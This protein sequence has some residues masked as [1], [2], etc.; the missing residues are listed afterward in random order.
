MREFMHDNEWWGLRD[1]GTWVRWNNESLE[2][3]AQAE[4]PPSAE[5][6][7][8]TKKPSPDVGAEQPASWSDSAAAPSPP[9]IPLPLR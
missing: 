5:M 4:P 7:E 9:R 2:W 1:D 6:R 3:D 8:V